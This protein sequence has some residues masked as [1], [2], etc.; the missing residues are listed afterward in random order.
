[1]QLIKLFEAI[2]PRSDDQIFDLNKQTQRIW[3]TAAT[4]NFNVAITS[5]NFL[6]NCYQLRLIQM[7]YKYLS[8]CLTKYKEFNIIFRRF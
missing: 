2:L 6:W 4:I 8:K 1:M 5:K 7:M 3:K